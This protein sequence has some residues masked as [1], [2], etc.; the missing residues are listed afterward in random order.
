[1]G[2]YNTT[3]VKAPLGEV[4]KRLR[5]FHDLSWAEGVIESNE[6]IGEF[7]GYQGGA[8]RVLNGVFHETLLDLDDEK[9]S[10]RYQI[11][12]GPGPLSRE[13][14]KGYIGQVRVSPV[15]DEGFTFVEWTSHWE[16][17]EGGVAEFCDP[18]Y[19]ALLGALKASFR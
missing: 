4:W 19:S 18:I 10:F 3:V 17:S 13:K 16:A 1:M 6:I 9:H 11:T 14:V 12:D 15:T 7:P 5:D 2:C 8:K